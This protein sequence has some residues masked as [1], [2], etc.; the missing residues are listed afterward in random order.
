[1][2]LP[3]FDSPARA[4]CTPSR[5]VTSRKWIDGINQD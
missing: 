3:N 2:T 5:L 4:V 1:M